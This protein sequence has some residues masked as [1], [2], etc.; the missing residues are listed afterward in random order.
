MTDHLYTVFRGFTIIAI[1][2]FACGESSSQEYIEKND[3]I[4]TQN[5]DKPSTDKYISKKST[6][7]EDTISIIGVG[8]IMFGTNYPPGCLPPDNECKSLIEPVAN[9]LRDADVTFGNNEG[10]FSNAPEKIRPCNGSKWCFRFN[11][12]ENF[13]KCYTYAGFDVVSI[14]N[15]HMN[16]S[17][18]YG[19]QNTVKV[20]KSEGIHFAG[21]KTHPTDTFIINGV[22]FGFCAFAPNTGTCRITDYELLKKTV[23]KLKEECRVVIVS[24]HGGAEGSKHQ[25]VTKNTEIFLGLN[26]GNVYK[27]AHTAIDAGADVVFGHGPHVTRAI[28]VYKKRFIAYSMGNFCTYRRFNIKGVNGIAPIIKI[29]VSKKGE[30]VKGKITATYQDK[31]TGTKLDKSNRVIKRMQELTKQDFP[32]SVIK[33]DSNGDVVYKN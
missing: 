6:T 21:L 26:R 15:N 29:F 17:G 22:K 5:Q 24:F 7:D 16:D 20:L 23:K 32:D 19:M 18:T 8:D 30:F 28:E 2:L 13:V 33:I 27:F 25:H 11:M 4:K 9:I 31:I 1:F 10:V 12:P 3:I 14:A